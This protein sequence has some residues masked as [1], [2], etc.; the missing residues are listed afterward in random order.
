MTFGWLSPLEACMVPSGTMRLV[1]RE[2]SFRTVLAQRL[3]GPV[4]KY[5]ISCII[6]IYFPLLMATKGYKQ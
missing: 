6:E 4:L 1:L 3:L 5:V 2:V